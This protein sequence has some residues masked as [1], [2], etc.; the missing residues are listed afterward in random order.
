M[1]GRFA[2]RSDSAHGAKTK[3]QVL[4]S[5]RSLHTLQLTS[6][7]A[8]LQTLLRE[9]VAP[10]IAPSH[11]DTHKPSRY[12]TL[13]HTRNAVAFVMKREHLGRLHSQEATS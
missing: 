10:T 6:L 8:H 2:R 9:T 4:T 1:S 13:V 7:P 3:D 12:R 5:T 11:F